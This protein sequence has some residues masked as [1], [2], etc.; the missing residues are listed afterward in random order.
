[1]ASEHPK[2][3]T[4]RL[5]ELKSQ[6]KEG[7]LGVISM[8]GYSTRRTTTI[9]Q[10]IN[11]L[12]NQ[13]EKRTRKM[14]LNGITEDGDNIGS[15]TTAEL[16]TELEQLRAEMA[17]LKLQQSQQMINSGN[18]MMQVIVNTD[19]LQQMKEF[20]KPFNGKPDE[21]VYKWLESIVHYFEVVKLPGEKEQLYF[22]YAPAFL[23]NYAYEWWKENRRT[24]TDWGMFRQL[25]TEQFGKINEYMVGQQL[26][27]RRQ[28]YNEPVIKYYYDVLELCEKYDSQMSV[29]QKVYR[30]T[31]GLQFSLYQEA[32]KESYASTAEFLTRVQQIET[33]QKLIEHRQM[34][35]QVPNDRPQLGAPGGYDTNWNDQRRTTRIIQC[36]RCNEN[37]HL[38]RDCPRNNPTQQT[39]QKNE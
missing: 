37:G 19:P 18:P 33:V 22:Q 21:N 31:N 4:D 36:Y 20:V 2:W 38:S 30:L 25:I 15:N 35:T 6:S 17:R 16:L 11:E 28:Q 1:M 12:A 24:V 26:D 32:V 14:P 34:Q 27:Q 13:L 5:I 8:H 9:Q 10:S 23:K 3:C 39:N 29:K 7:F